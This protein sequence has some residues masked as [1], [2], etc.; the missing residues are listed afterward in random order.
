MNTIQ[1]SILKSYLSAILPV[2]VIGILSI[3]FTQSNLTNEALQRR[4][5]T[6]SLGAKVLQEK[7][8]RVNDLG[9]SLTTRVKFRKLIEQNKFDGAIDIVRDVPQ[10]FQ[11][12]SDLHILS[13]NGLSQRS[14]PIR[15]KSE[16]FS[17]Y[18]WFNLLKT[19]LQSTISNVY[20]SDH[21]DKLSYTF[22]IRK[23]G[24]E[25]LILG[26]LVLD[27]DIPS[28]IE[29][30]KEYTKT[31]EGILYFLDANH[32]LIGGSSNI[33]HNSIQ[34]SI[35][36][37]VQQK[38]QEAV[39]RSAKGDKVVAYNYLTDNKWLVIFEENESDVFSSMYQTLLFLTI[40]FIIIL[41]IALLFAKQRVNSEKQTLIAAQKIEESAESIKRK[42]LELSQ[43]SS[44]A[45]HDLKAPIRGI[46][47]LCNMLQEDCD[48]LKQDDKEILQKIESRSKKMAQ[49]I[50]GFL[51]IAQVGEIKTTAS[52]LDLPSFLQEV[53]DEL[54]KS[55]N[56]QLDY[57]SEL[58]EVFIEPFYIQQIF[59]NLF[60]NAI[61]YTDKENIILSI[62]IQESEGIY[63]FNFWDNGP[64]IHAQF[65]KEIFRPYKT[66]HNEGTEKGHGVGLAIVQKIIQIKSK[67][68]IEV[69][70]P[71]NKIGVGFRF[72]LKK[73]KK[74]INH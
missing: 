63:Y 60:S 20:Q 31:S 48:Y 46:A 39:F 34:L 6:A 40:V 15:K 30:S 18:S 57:Q 51:S 50:D 59:Q 14:I 67:D 41:I 56:V 58:K 19:N 9:K 38:Q 69:Y 8:E 3:L 17:K 29:W 23:R 43:F 68:P 49:I 4:D 53:I 7:L 35:Q 65:H 55:N 24:D 2:L 73:S 5:S 32:T 54:S 22:P 47:L 64:G 45:S 70:T 66:L 21:S 27:I 62:K 28:F 11:F 10:N 52:T 13:T 72:N 1:K 16:D 71:E 37:I 36:E 61:K 25:K 12:V 74:K 33:E 44:M 26:Y 42:N